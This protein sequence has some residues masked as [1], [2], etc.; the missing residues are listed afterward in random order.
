MA[1]LSK[2]EHH[3]RYTVTLG[4][5]EIVAFFTILLLVA[6]SLIYMGKLAERVSV[7]EKHPGAGGH[8]PLE[9]RV[10]VTETLIGVNAAG[11][12]RVESDVDTA[13]RKLDALLTRFSVTLPGNS[14]HPRS[15]P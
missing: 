3:S 9:R 13:N 2:T 15:S 8:P 10:A 4:L 1:P 6:P 11:I 7:L 5:K 14:N 12:A